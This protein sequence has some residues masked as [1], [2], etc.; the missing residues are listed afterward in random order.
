MHCT[1]IWLAFISHGLTHIIE[2]CSSISKLRVSYTIGLHHVNNRHNHNI[3][4][5][6]D[7][8]DSPG[9]IHANANTNANT[10]VNTNVNTNI[11]INVNTKANT[12]A[13]TVHINNSFASNTDTRTTVNIND[14]TKAVRNDIDV[15]DVD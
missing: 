11:N 8:N 6:T 15:D 10:N 4:G 13:N 2:L 5:S 3:N 7:Y 1:G 12:N 9:A 14:N